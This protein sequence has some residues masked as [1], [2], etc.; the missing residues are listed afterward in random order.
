MRTIRYLAL[1]LSLLHSINAFANPQKMNG[2]AE[3][4]DF[5]STIYIGS[6]F[7]PE[8]AN[9]LEAIQQM[10]G[11]KRMEIH[12]YD[13]RYAIRTF[14]QH[15]ASWSSFGA[16]T[17]QAPANNINMEKLYS[18]KKD[19]NTALGRRNFTRGDIFIVKN[20]REG[21]T[22]IL[23]NN[24]ELAS[25]KSSSMFDF[26]LNAWIGEPAANPVFKQ[27]ILN[28]DQSDSIT[29]ELITS[30]YDL[31]KD[32]SYANKRDVEAPAI[33]AASKRSTNRKAIIMES[34]NQQINSARVSSSKKD[35]SLDQLV[36]H[37]A[38]YNKL[39]EMLKKSIE[40]EIDSSALAG[41]KAVRIYF[42][43]KGKVLSA[44]PVLQA[45][46]LGKKQKVAGKVNDAIARAANKISPI[47]I[48]PAIKYAGIYTLSLTLN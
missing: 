19:I 7:L 12:F 40:S 18:L 6:L 4:N 29:E 42:N 36:S 15:V 34:A 46:R 20:T 37:T 47:P 35:T 11:E 16:S 8:P 24:N 33:T 32:K 31:V 2:I 28:L 5:G 44:T 23:V 38:Y 48:S 26:I 22:K 3:F 30:Y 9:N 41:I 43:D 27:D 39:K 25:F 45:I 21:G 14:L 13:S 10:N 1:A 17:T